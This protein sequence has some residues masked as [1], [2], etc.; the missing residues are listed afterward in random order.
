MYN[1]Q[2]T[3]SARSYFKKL[4]KKDKAL[5]ERLSIAIEEITMNPYQA[6]VL[7]KGDLSGIYGYDVYHQ[8][9][10]YEIAYRLDTDDDG[11]TILILL[12]GSRE[13]FYEQ[14]KRYMK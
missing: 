6:G 3:N 13:N 5:L 11:N 9:T 8:G 7:K 10:N 4:K 1:V 12:A 14:L 2:Y